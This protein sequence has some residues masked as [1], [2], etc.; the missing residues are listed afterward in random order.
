MV[1]LEGFLV[2]LLILSYIH[3]DHDARQA[4]CGVFEP[5]DERWG[6]LSISEAEIHLDT[7]EVF[8]RFEVEREEN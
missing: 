5:P 7:S 2:Y 8:E 1:R 6:L 3:P 4:R